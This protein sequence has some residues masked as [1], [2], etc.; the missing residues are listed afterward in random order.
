VLPVRAVCDHDGQLVR[1]DL[2][3]ALIV[4]CAALAGCHDEHWL[5]YPWDDRR[6]LC[7][8]PVDD[9]TVDV[10]WDLVED[11]MQVAEHTQA[12]LLLHA[13]VPGTTISLAGIERVLT[14]ADEHH[15][16][17]VTFRELDEHAPPR[18][19]LA[20]AFDDNSIDA[21]FSIRDLLDVHGA[22]VTFF[23]TRW[24]SRSDSERA[25]LRT[26]F[27]EGH[28][29]EPHSVNHLHAPDYV[30]EHGLDAYMA[31]EAMP[32]IDGLTQAGYPAPAVY[33]YPFG[34]DSEQLDAALLAIVPRVRV[35]PGSC[36]Y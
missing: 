14:M 2:P 30:S 17:F 1:S 6:I 32:S 35:S 11:Q 23:V 7:S 21:W 5:T 18:A 34:R 20:F 15:L 29:V 13:H 24:Y 36:P 26:L 4:V 12:V 8:Q 31:D 16:A 10:P 28:D 33:A 9:E 19:G 3:A 22:H 27:D 25:E